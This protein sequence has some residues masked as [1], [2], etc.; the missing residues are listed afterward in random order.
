[1]PKPVGFA[2]KVET[3]SN[4]RSKSAAKQKRQEKE[5]K[6]ADLRRQGC[7]EFSIFVRIPDREWLP[8]GT[9]AVERSNQ[10]NQAIFQQEA[11]LRKNIFRI[12]PKLQRFQDQLE[13]GYRLKEFPDEPITKAVRPTAKAGGNSF[14]RAW[15]RFADFWRR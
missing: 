7:P 4:S 1:M 5:Q 14:T 9:M 10:I 3:K 11:E 13:F 12:L 2:P 6:F 15:Q 8:A